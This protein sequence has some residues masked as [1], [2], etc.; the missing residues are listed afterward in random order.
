MRTRQILPLLAATGALAALCPT[1]V[2]AQ[3]LSSIPS[4]TPH[5]AQPYKAPP[6]LPPA[7]PGAQSSPSQAAPADKLPA[8]MS[9][10][11]ALFDAVER[12][13][14]SA[15]RDALN[16][17][18]DV[19]AQNSLHLTPL[20]ESIDLGRKDI[21]FLLL[22]SRDGS[23]SAAAETAAL[24]AKATGKTASKT[25]VVKTRAERV[26]VEAKT[27]ATVHPTV[28]QNAPLFAGNTGTPVPQAGFL[29]FG[30]ST[31]IR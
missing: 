8:D 18:A 22:S 21:A 26:A 2:R 29:G 20:D 24:A 9:P 11:D 3:G 5:T 25:R 14:I 23:I 27:T 16:R 7:L 17:G 13:D 4:P 15:A 31:Q 10:N 1:A 30:G 12:G 28:P 6:P 19:N